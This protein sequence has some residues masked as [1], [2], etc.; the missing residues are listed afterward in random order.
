MIRSA[1]T[2]YLLGV[3]AKERTVKSVNAHAAL[4]PFCG[5]GVGLETFG[6][7]LDPQRRNRSQCFCISAMSDR[8]TET[9]DG[10]GAFAI[11]EDLVRSPTHKQAT[12][13]VVDFDGLLYDQPLQLHEDL[14]NGNGGRAWIAGRVLTKYL[15]RRKRDELMHASMFV[16]RRLLRAVCRYKPLTL[17]QR[18]AGCGRWTCWVNAHT[19]S[20]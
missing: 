12:T 16:G 11:S 15:L 4:L 14:Q 5:V 18:G 3:G 19:S 17:G 8:E 6:P 2:S 20:W 10:L 7:G 1:R 13:N 9:D